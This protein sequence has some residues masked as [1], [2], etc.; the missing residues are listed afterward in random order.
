MK[1]ARSSG[2]LC[3]ITSLP[4]RFG[5][6]DLGPQA[7]RFADWLR[8]TRQN[9]WQILPLNPTGM[10]MSNSPYGSD[11]A[12]AGDPLVISLERLIEE[13][14]LTKADL[15]G[16]PAFPDDRVDY[17]AVRAYRDQL[18]DLAWSRL[19]NA[20]F[21]EDFDLYCND[22][23]FWL[24]DYALFLALK[25]RFGGKSWSHWPADL[26]DR[27]PDALKA[28]AKDLAAMVRRVKVFQ[29]LFYSQWQSLR[30]YCNDHLVQ[31]IGD[32]PYYVA[33]DSA[34]VWA[35]PEL[36]KL[37]KNKKPTFV[38]GTPPD[39]FSRDGQLRGMPVYD[40]QANERAGYD[41]WVQ[42]MEQN[43][44][45]YDLVRVDH[46]RGFLGTWQVPAGH[47]TAKAGAWEQHPQHRLMDKLLRRRP[48]LQVIA[49]DLGLI[50]PDV[51][52]FMYKFDLPGMR[53]LQLCF[54]EQLP[55]DAHVPHNHHHNSFVYTGTHDNNTAR[56]WF[57]TDADAAT[58]QRVFAYL[59]RKVNGKD[60][61]W[62]LIRL[63]MMSVAGTAILP[64]QDVLSL[65]AE[66][67]MNTP[68]I[69][70]GNWA[71][72][73]TWKQITPELTRRLADMTTM[74]GR[75]R[76]ERRQA[77]RAGGSLANQPPPPQQ[78]RR[79]QV[80][81]DVGAQQEDGQLH[82]QGDRAGVPQ[83]IEQ[84]VAYRVDDVQRP[85]QQ[86]PAVPAEHP[87]HVDADARQSHDRR[88]EE[89]AP[90][91]AGTPLHQPLHQQQ[92]HRP[93]QAA[94]DGERADQHRVIAMRH[95]RDVPQVDEVGDDVRGVGQE[96]QP[97]CRQQRQHPRPARRRP[98]QQT[99]P[100][101]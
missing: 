68:G 94:R 57:E 98:A 73:F 16:A 4:S 45:L 59:G 33:Y 10:A 101:G 55:T 60:I 58:R 46:F 2:V 67:R 37:D 14:I 90:Q 51:R 64:L 26:R 80:E 63:A 17:K 47:K 72:R 61:S 24:N 25:G 95:R 1:L 8:E 54:H 75:A 42:R 39:Y 91:P 49:E 65:G 70:E 62:E 100:P 48:Y 77:N 15:A 96:R 50:T 66:A 79:Q 97:S 19:Q 86:V 20:E 18:F 31:L 85:R 6:G 21:S 56:G 53:V 84:C 93:Q 44:L 22:N 88:R 92:R 27:K 43:L 71:W 83:R 38:A 36:W 30:R 69:A 12:F 7:Y 5:V 3:H 11:S 41:W 78:P 76:L 74:F 32:V 13:D 35:R 29:Y 9:R 40:W 34:D 87:P 99:Q 23:H 52:E 82:A 28:A 89:P 81:Q